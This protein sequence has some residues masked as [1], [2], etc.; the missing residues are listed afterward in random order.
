MSLNLENEKEINLNKLELKE[1]SSIVP[2]L[3]TENVFNSN[4]IDDIAYVDYTEN[5]KGLTC[6]KPLK[7]LPDYIDDLYIFKY[8]HSN[9]IEETTNN[10]NKIFLKKGK[11][12]SASLIVKKFTTIT[13]EVFGEFCEQ[14][15]VFLVN[16]QNEK[17]KE[18]SIIFQTLKNIEKRT[19]NAAFKGYEKFYKCKNPVAVIKYKVNT[20]RLSLK[21][22]LKNLNILEERLNLMGAGLMSIDYTRDLSGVLEKERMIKHFLKLGFIEQAESE[23]ENKKYYIVNEFTKFKTWDEKTAKNDDGEDIKNKVKILD[24]DATCGRNTFKYIRNTGSVCCVVKYYNKI[25]S[26]FEAG[27]VQKKIGTHL[28]EYAF[29]H[30]CE[31]LDVIERGLTRLEIS[32]HGFNPK[33]NYCKMLEEEFNLVKYAKIFHIQPGAEQWLRLAKHITQCSLFANKATHE[34][35]LFW[36]GS[37]VTKRVAGVTKKL[38]KENIDANPEEWEHA[39]KWVML[40]FGFSGVPIYNISLDVKSVLEEKTITEKQKNP[41]EEEKKEEKPKKEKKEKPKQPKEQEE[42]DEEDEEEEKPKEPKPKRKQGRPTKKEEEERRSKLTKE[43]IKR[44]DEEKERKRKEGEEK[45]KIKAEEMQ[46]EIERR[47]N[48]T[49]EERLEEEKERQEEEKRKQRKREERK[50]PKCEKVE[51]VITEENLKLIIE[52]FTYCLK[53]GPTFL[54]PFNQ[55]TKM[56][57][58]VNEKK[59]KEPPCPKDEIFKYPSKILPETENI[60]WRFRKEPDHKRIGIKKLPKYP[61]QYF[62]NPDKKISTNSTRERNTLIYL[63]QEN[64]KSKEW[65]K[66][67]NNELKLTREE[68]IKFKKD[69]NTKINENLKDTETIAL[70]EERKNTVDEVF[71]CFSNPEEIVNVLNENEYIHIFAFKS[72]PNCMRI[73]YKVQDDIKVC[74]A[75]PLLEHMLMVYAIHVLIYYKR[76][77]QNINQNT[78][79]ILC[80]TLHSKQREKMETI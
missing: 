76:K 34:I 27:D 77:K 15:I 31:H 30:S 45:K 33:I 68:K 12:K 74:F 69:L 52:D 43:Q 21:N 53:K 80:L 7:G 64:E 25:V 67:K 6:L 4:L 28:S 65:I 72:Y 75:N 37:S 71:R 11:D 2:H 23:E 48:L 41:N 17:D 54:T 58:S 59:V 61:F 9:E 5:S 20:S 10:A 39:K 50:K 46:K 22:V 57:M 51:K 40:N 44:E 3:A 56:Y 63:E 73:A 78:Q 36:Y 35:S 38:K 79:F 29:T 70:Y 66:D 26:N 19:N 60:Q 49:H 1:L 13:T 18:N 47:K 62:K 14:K 32:I 8:I 55:P 42:E 24:T 16:L